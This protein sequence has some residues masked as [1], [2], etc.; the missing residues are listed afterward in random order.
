MRIHVSLSGRVLKFPPKRRSL[1]NVRDLHADVQSSL[2]MQA[3]VENDVR[4]EV[5]ALRSAIVKRRNAYKPFL[6]KLLPLYQV[7]IDPFFIAWYE[8]DAEIP[9]NATLARLF[10]ER[11][12]REVVRDLRKDVLSIGDL[13]SSVE[14]LGSKVVVPG[15]LF[16]STGFDSLHQEY[17]YLLRD[18][19]AY[20]KRVAQ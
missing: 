13:R 10:F 3:I 5:K 16:S 15:F 6:A 18:I 14:K 2:N 20:L 4:K 8:T 7:G 1:Q 17:V 11:Y 9:E 19:T 12:G